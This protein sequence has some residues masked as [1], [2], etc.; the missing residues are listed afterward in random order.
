MPGQFGN[1]R[2]PG[3][4]S[5]VDAS[6]LTVTGLTS[7]GVIGVVG[8]STAGDPDTVY[9][10]SNSSEAV[11]A[12][13]GGALLDVI[14][15]AYA[16]GAQEVYA[17]R[18][19]NPARAACVIGK[20]ANPDILT[21]TSK[22]YGSAFNDLEVLVDSGGGTNKRT[23]TIK[24][25]NNF[26]SVFEIY[27]DYTTATGLSA[28]ITAQSA[29][30]T[31][32][33]DGS[34]DLPDVLADYVSFSG[35]SDGS[36]SVLEVAD[37]FQLLLPQDVDLILLDT[38]D[39]TYHALALAHCI[40]ASNALNR[41]ERICILGLPS[42]NAVA[43]Y[44]AQAA[45]LANKRAVLVAPCGYT[46]DFGIGD[47]TTSLKDGHIIAAVVAGAIAGL[48]DVA[49]PLTKKPVPFVT[50]LEVD[51]TNG[52]L[53]TLIDG[54]VLAVA[55]RREGQSVVKQLTTSGSTDFEEISVVRTVDY[56]MKDL[57]NGADQLF[58][59]KKGTRNFLS[60]LKGW[61][62]GKLSQYVSQ[63]LLVQYVETSVTA[64]FLVDNQK[65]VNLSFGAVPVQPVNNIGIKGAF[66]TLYNF[67][68]LV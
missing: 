25:E 19:G 3:A 6:G 47:T 35:G 61:A 18:V 59:G 11:N 24:L 57:R 55:R 20:T 10:F 23:I 7:V 41:S 22:G 30:V 65:W 15:A 29:V 63:D 14:R 9:K 45:A 1:V 52:E 27:P 46:P 8:I 56:I 36:R 43:D 40:E 68:A 13:Q 32:A 31:A 53:G 4:V 58:V 39:D 67:S 21:L 38:A 17:V 34:A 66:S 16:G 60:S 49:E 26:Y 44:T 33:N 50:Q 5:V 12:L 37:G 28:A 2:I 62:K 51:Y 48:P 54:K 42:G 64:E